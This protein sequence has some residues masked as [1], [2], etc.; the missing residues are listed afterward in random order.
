MGKFYDIS[1]RIERF[2]AIDSRN[3]FRVCKNLGLELD[4]MGLSDKLYF[5]YA[6]V[7]WVHIVVI[8]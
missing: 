3:D 7:Q 2:S 8:I 6:L 5:S 1:D 4:P